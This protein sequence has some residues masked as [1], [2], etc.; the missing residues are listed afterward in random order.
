[1]T[2]RKLARFAENLTFPNMFQLSFEE[3]TKGIPWRGK[4][5]D[6]FQNQNPIILELGCGKGE[7]TINLAEKNPD[8]N[9]I[10][11]DIKGAR[12]WR[13]CK[14]SQ[15][16]GLS[17]VAFI[18]TYVQVLEQYFTPGEIAEIWITFPD[19]QPRQ[20]REKRRLTHP[21]FLK[22][23]HNLLADNGLIHLKT[24]NQD[25]FNY[26]LS[27]ITEHNHSLLYSSH[28]L[29]HSE[30]APAETLTIQT[31]YEKMFLEEGKPICYLKFIINTP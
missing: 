29:Y 2:K 27:V 23:Y 16:K 1:M 19:P 9:Y 13:G 17:N 10:G 4:W 11:I 30:D 25:F 31:F 7:Y 3:Q 18:R 14:T 28:D 8:R 5:H 6:F 12:M 22:I 26:T 24:D 15:E 21:R 20:A